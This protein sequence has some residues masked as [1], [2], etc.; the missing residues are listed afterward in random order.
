MFSVNT[1]L[2]AMA[3]LNSLNMV[4]NSLKETQNQ[5]ST[6]K[7]ISSASD[8]P[9]VYTIAQTMQAN[10]QGLTAVSD[11]LNFGT[12]VV[13]TAMSAT[14]QIGSVLAQLKNTITQGQ[15][16][17]MDANAMN[18]QIKQAIANVNQIAQSATFN[19]VNLTASVVAGASTGVG[20]TSSTLSVVDNV[21]G[22]TIS[23]TPGA[24]GAGPSNTNITTASDATGLGLSNVSVSDGSNTIQFVGAATIA[25]NDYFTL[26][27]KNAAGAATTYNFILTDGSAAPTI[28]S[29]STS[30]NVNVLVN[31]NSA[32]TPGSPQVDSLNQIL[33]KFASSMQSQGFGAV[34][35]SSGTLNVTGN[36]VSTTAPTWSGTAADVNVTA[37]ASTSKSAIAEVDAAIKQL[38]TN[39]A[40]LGAVSNQI[41]GM[42]TY[43]SQLSTALTAGIGALTDADMAAESAKLQSLQTKQSLAIQS[44]S[45][46]NQQPQSIMT[47][48]R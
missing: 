6:G 21:A 24:D 3:A 15:Q 4:E 22:G 13:S 8:N 26:T 12:S 28:P 42:S 43:T 18:A 10:V 29:A 23:V 44:L 9:A 16:T 47:L 31:Y 45:I 39:S 32:S 17:G 1:N 36:G 2:G 7:K 35:D 48:F 37:P 40:Y 34:V 5:I 11:S 19:G 33:S 41:S 20:A 30:T 14:S 38:N 46:A 27:G 25:S